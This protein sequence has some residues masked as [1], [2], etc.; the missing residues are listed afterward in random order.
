MS[1]GVNVTRH[2]PTQGHD[3]ACRTEGG[4]RDFFRAS[5]HL[6]RVAASSVNQSGRGGGN[7]SGGG[8]DDATPSYFGIR[9][10]HTPNPIH[11]ERR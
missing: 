11:L 4:E 5:T 7:H 8:V 1:C 6:L 2:A 9:H 10:L 3:R